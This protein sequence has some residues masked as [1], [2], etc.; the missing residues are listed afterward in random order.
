MARLAAVTMGLLAMAIMV[1][2]QPLQKPRF[3]PPRLKTAELPPLPAPTVAAGGE[4]LIEALV[5]RTGA[6]L[7]PVIIRGTPPYTQFVLDVVAHWRFEPARDIDDKGVDTTVAM[8]VTIFAL[9]RPPV[10]MNAPTPGEPPKDWGKLSGEA[11]Y[12]TATAMPNYPPQARN[13]GVVLMEIS[14]DEAGGVT[15]TRG[16]ESA[17]GFERA[18]HQ[19][20]AS[21][22]FK[23]GSYRARPVPS[24]A[25]VIFGFRVPVGLAR[26]SGP[27]PTP[28]V[29]S[30]R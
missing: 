5:D 6:L 16:F 7:R 14:L 13:G 29:L 11:A 19:A 18:S 25:Y 12:P 17:G 23:G 15:D 10:L 2:A 1:S 26:S 24:T 3:V 9:Y 8:P 22:R 21:W 20:V 28:G 4:V 27:P 30:F